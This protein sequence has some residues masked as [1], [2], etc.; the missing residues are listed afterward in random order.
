MDHHAPLLRAVRVD[1]GEV[2]SLGLVE[3]ELDGG[4]GLLVPAT[5]ADLQVGLWPLEGRFAVGLHQ[6]DLFAGQHF[7]GS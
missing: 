7:E 2:E 6:V 3:V 5:V 4:D 1:V